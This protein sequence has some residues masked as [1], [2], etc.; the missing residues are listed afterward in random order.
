MCQ[1]SVLPLSPKDEV[2]GQCLVKTLL[3]SH[4]RIEIY[5]I[6]KVRLPTLPVTAVSNLAA[7]SHLNIL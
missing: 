4:L 6:D 5:H 7:V 1:G 3:I 2:P